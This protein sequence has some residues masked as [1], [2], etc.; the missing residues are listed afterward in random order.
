[1]NFRHHRP[2]QAWALRK[3]TAQC[4]VEKGGPNCSRARAWPNGRCSAGLPRTYRTLRKQPLKTECCLRN[5]AR[6]EVLTSVVD[7]LRQ[8]KSV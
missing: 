3:R 4:E 5:A 7:R 1:M 2:W 6:R 8:Q